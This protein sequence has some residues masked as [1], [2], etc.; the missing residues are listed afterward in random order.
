[1]DMCSSSLLSQATCFVVSSSELLKKDPKEVEV[2]NSGRDNARDI[3]DILWAMAS[4]CEICW[5]NLRISLA[6]TVGI[7]SIS[8]CGNVSACNHI[9]AP[10]TGPARLPVAKA[11]KTEGVPGVDEFFLY[12]LEAAA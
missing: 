8:F 9:D 12:K 7:H 11:A 2:W 4:D 3:R 1:M 6:D 10:E 5:G